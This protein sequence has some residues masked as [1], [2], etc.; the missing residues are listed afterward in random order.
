MS[1]TIKVKKSS[2]ILV[3][4]VSNCELYFN[5]VFYFIIVFICLFLFFG[6]VDGTQVLV[7]VKQALYPWA[8]SWTPIFKYK[9]Q[10]DKKVL[11][12]G[13]GF[14]V[15]HVFSMGKALATL[16]GILLCSAPA[17]QESDISTS[18][19]PT[20]LLICSVLRQGFAM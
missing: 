17:P 3:W 16:S 7:F 14:V 9:I 18:L 1:I 8:I 12:K 6:S 10:S 15:K 13:W 19:S 4:I 11:G 5:F 2:N 20:P